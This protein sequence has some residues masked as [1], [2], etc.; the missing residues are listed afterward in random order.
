[1]HILSK[2]LFHC[3]AKSSHYLLPAHD[4]LIQ[5]TI[6]YFRYQYSKFKY[7]NSHPF[8]LYLA[9]SR[10]VIIGQLVKT[11]CISGMICILYRANNAIFV[12]SFT[13]SKVAFVKYASP[14]LFGSGSPLFGDSVFS[15][16][17][18]GKEIKNTKEAITFI[19]QVN[20]F[21]GCLL[22]QLLISLSLIWVC[23]SFTK[24]VEAIIEQCRTYQLWVNNSINF[25]VIYPYRLLLTYFVECGHVSETSECLRR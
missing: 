4:K 21:Q 1:M 25:C 14:A 20:Q 7:Q 10:F 15:A 16:S 6:Q 3:L 9:G 17:I 22:F 11:L 23:H 19:M 5:A 2:K 18:S 13:G 24:P 12:L 8:I